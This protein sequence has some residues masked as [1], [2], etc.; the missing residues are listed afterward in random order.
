M[1][2]DETPHPTYVRPTKEE[3]A[4]QTPTGR[5]ENPHLK[6]IAERPAPR[7]NTNG[8]NPFQRI[9]GG[10]FPEHH[11][12][13]ER[14]LRGVSQ[15]QRETI[16]KWGVG[17]TIALV[18]AVGGQHLFDT[19]KDEIEKT[20]KLS[21][22]GITKNVPIYYYT[23]IL[24][25]GS[26][27]GGKYADPMVAFLRCDDPATHTAILAEP[28]IA[29]N[30]KIAYWPSSMAERRSWTVMYMELSATT[31]KEE[32]KG[33]IR[34][35]VREVMHTDEEIAQV[36][37][38]I[39]Q[40]EPGPRDER[41]DSLA[42]SVDAQY[43][44]HESK[45]VIVIYMDRRK[46]SEP[47]QETLGELL[48][49]KVY[50]TDAIQYKPIVDKFTGKI[51]E[52]VI[53]KLDDH[54]SYL[55]P[56]TRAKWWGPPDQIS[57]LPKDH[58]LVEKNKREG[59][60]T[61]EAEEAGTEAE[62]GLGLEEAAHC[63]P[64]AQP[65]PAKST[66]C[67]RKSTGRETGEGTRIS[68]VTKVTIEMRR[69]GGTYL[70]R[71]P[72]VGSP[73][74]HKALAKSGSYLTFATEGLNNSLHAQNEQ[75]T[76][77]EHA[78]ERALT[79][80]ESRGVRGSATGLETPE[81]RNRVG[82]ELANRRPEAT[83]DGSHTPNGNGAYQ[84]TE[85]GPRG[86]TLDAAGGPGDTNRGVDAQQTRR[87]QQETPTQDEHG[88]A[89]G[90]SVNR[91]HGD[92]EEVRP[93][94]NN[95]QNGHARPSNTRDTNRTNP[96]NPEPRTQEH[97]KRSKK[98]MKAAMK[99]AGLNIRGH[100]NTNVHHPDNKW[101]GVW[102]IM[103]EE[104][105]AILVIGEAHMNLERK[106]EIDKLFGRK[107]HLEFTEAP[108]NTNSAGL[109]VVMNKNM[110]ATEGVR[111]W[112]VI[113][114]RA[115]I[116]ETK[117]AD[118]S[119][120][121]V[122]GVYAPNDAAANRKFWEEINKYFD[123][124]PRVRKPDTMIGDMNM[125]EGAIDRLPT[126]SDNNNTVNAL[127]ELKIRLRIIDGWRETYP[128]T[129]DYTFRQPAALGGSLSRI[130]R[131]YVKR[132]TFSNTFDWGIKRV[133]IETDHDMTWMKITTER[134][135]TVGR[136]RW[137]W[138]AHVIKDKVLAE[139]IQETGMELERELKEITASEDRRTRD[140]NAQTLWAAFKSKIGGKARER[141]KTLTPKI[142]Q[143]IAELELKLENN[144]TAKKEIQ[145]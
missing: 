41:I 63:R 48:R 56:F 49:K 26:K 135:P 47:E 109:A 35:T 6:L 74:M 104:K 50:V 25:S 132:D 53:C 12:S 118:G 99:L 88:A 133:G 9:Q 131:I 39:T 120:L 67:T 142:I 21:L 122:L 78:A 23:P 10:T 136:G 137:A 95:I 33:Q 65:D 89:T 101:L 97:S 72:P 70:G 40:M 106:N 140:R 90:E 108:G 112:E 30:T 121:S 45:P 19:L 138:P 127:D 124:N 81:E 4:T 11:I 18:F 75:T 15:E 103:R 82:G 107:M 36:I 59:D 102:Q 123:D 68:M 31:N 80:T 13:S 3:F 77:D 24:D 14:L 8:E 28:F 119:P 43:L 54:P 22:S 1:M 129:R 69:N 51:R 96:D 83:R 76:T 52:C 60:G 111:T 114:G 29:V 139:Y 42:L 128:E 46:G 58:P 143:E 110:I 91:T 84:V 145:L 5:D 73:D 61:E 125:V 37:D 116:L 141:A 38:R 2:T 57:A 94:D 86:A 92:H 113:Q 98:T 66:G 130:D 64:G 27:S 144:Q 126:H 16:E 71:S 44:D 87:A 85:D 117:H 17:K 32:M 20:V 105:I 115:M 93:S 62:D 34:G 134:A 100:G 55:C 79:T 7:P